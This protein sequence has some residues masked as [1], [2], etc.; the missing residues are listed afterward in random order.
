MTEEIRKTYR[1]VEKV[2]E[3][4]SV[5]TI[6]LVIDDGVKKNIVP[7]F[8][9]GQFINVYFPELGTPEGKAYSISSS[10]LEKTLNIT[11]KAMGQFSNK[12]CALEKGDMITASLPYG[13]FYSESDETSIVMIAG[14]IGIAPFRSM[15]F[16]AA[17]RTPQR[18]LRLFCSYRAAADI[19]FRKELDALSAAAPC[20][21]KVFYF[22]TR[23]E[24]RDPAVISGRMSVNDIIGNAKKGRKNIAGREFF[25]CGS[26]QFVGSFWKALRKQGVLEEMMCTESFFSH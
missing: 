16:D 21:F 3:A 25:M 2:T 18:K 6:K 4:P 14:G 20:D 10:P 22:V 1:V 24:C 13:Y 15:I 5:S 11:V 26:I 19:I 23:E 17:A 7:P 8:H 9:P 12:L